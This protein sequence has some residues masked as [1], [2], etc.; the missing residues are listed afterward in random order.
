VPSKQRIVWL[1]LLLFALPAVVTTALLTQNVK[2]EVRDGAQPGGIVKGN[3]F[4]KEHH[5]VAGIDVTGWTLTQDGDATLASTT[6]TDAKGAFEL[7]L[8][9]V[10]GHYVVRFTGTEWQEARIAFGWLDAN[11]NKIEP[12]ALQV[13]MEAGCSLDVD[14]VRADHGPA[15]AGTFELQ[16]VAGGGLFAGWTGE[17]IERR[18]SFD[19]GSFTVTGLP[20]MHGRLWITMANGERIDSTLDLAAGKNHHKIDL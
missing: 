11:G 18:G 2:R 17:R 10:S 8:P 15:G 19:A 14:L 20:P 5:A 13:Q 16:G 9:P 4:D 6:Q 7:A 12:D 3:V 1:V